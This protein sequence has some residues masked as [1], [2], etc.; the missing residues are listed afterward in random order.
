MA[1]RIT[2]TR[3]YSAHTFAVRH[4]RLPSLHPHQQAGAA[5]HKCSTSCSVQHILTP[6]RVSAAAASQLGA[7]PSIRRVPLLAPFSRPQ[8]RQ[9]QSA[10]VEG[11]SNTDMLAHNYTNAM[12]IDTTCVSWAV[13]DKDFARTTIWTFHIFGMR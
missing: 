5:L 13:H 9:L 11:V 10:Y 1:C 6:A 7:S 12:Q 3:S 2:H 4:L 8:H